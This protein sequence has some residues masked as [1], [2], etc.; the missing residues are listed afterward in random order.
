MLK[1]LR[2]SLCVLGVAGACLAADTTPAPDVVEEIV[3][4]VNNEI[5]TRGEMDKFRRQVEA[6]V[7]HQQMNAERAKQV[8]KDAETDLLRDRIDQL[9]MVAKAKELRSE[10]RRVG[11]ECRSRWSP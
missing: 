1:R 11:K 8:L 9:L 3:A 2:V 6:E 10:E 4:K 5:V 7:A